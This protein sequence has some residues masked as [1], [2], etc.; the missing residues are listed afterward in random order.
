M[1]ALSYLRRTVLPSEVHRLTIAA[2]WFGFEAVRIS[3]DFG[4]DLLFFASTDQ[5]R[6]FTALIQ[7]ICPGL[8]VYRIRPSLTEA[9]P[10][11][12]NIWLGVYRPR[13]LGHR[14]EP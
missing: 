11:A 10:L 13:F 9:L 8:E 5:R 2:R 1:A 3:G 14:I 7:S 12:V 4:W 6:R